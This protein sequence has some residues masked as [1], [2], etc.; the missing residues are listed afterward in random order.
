MKMQNGNAAAIYCRLS[1]DEDTN[2]ESNSIASQRLMLTD[3][4]KRQGFHVVDEYVDDG[5]SGTNY[6]RPDFKRMMED[7]EKGLFGVIITKDLSRLGRDY[8]TTGEYMEKIFPRLNIRYIAMNDGYDSIAENDGNVDFAPIRNYFNEWYAK[9]CSRKTRASFKAMAEAGKFIGSKAPFGYIKNPEDKHHLLVDEEAAAIVRK[10]F[11]YA[12]SGLGYKAISK[13]L[14]DED[15]LNPNAYNNIVDPTFYKSNYWR[16]PHDWHPS[17]IKTILTNPT[18]LG[19]VVNGRR[20]TKSFKC[21]ELIRTPPEEWIVVEDMHEPIIDKRVWDEAQENLQK[22]KRSGHNGAIQIF[23]GLL[24]CADCGYSM[25]YSRNNA[26]HHNGSYRCSLYNV[27]GK[28]YCSSHYITY[29]ALY[30][31]VLADIQRKAFV[32]RLFQDNF[33][34]TLTAQTAGTLREKL[35][36]AEKDLKRLSSRAVELEQIISKLYED[37]ALGRITADRFEGFMLKFEA[38]KKQVESG[39]KNAREVMEEEKAQ[40]DNAQHFTEVILSYADLKELSAP[41]LNELIDCIEI[42]QKEVV[43][44]EKTQSIRILY[45]QVGY[46]EM[47][48]PQEL[49]GDEAI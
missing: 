8:L 29:D 30:Q 49:F 26:A 13:R 27:K 34:R 15:I 38:E 47:F 44:G 46:V 24:K 40:L 41:I 31:I 17:S 2:Q 23:A 14:R 20:K 48:S 32:A 1:R 25:A 37:H 39:L 7:A 43:D 6:D 3:F 22:R 36:K 42:G 4:A 35:K 21:Q 18:Y 33:M 9:D 45:K 16:Q 10:I 28:N 5:F 19:H 11:D 12:V